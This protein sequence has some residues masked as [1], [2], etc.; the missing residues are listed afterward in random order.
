M[1]RFMLSHSHGP[2]ECGVV[3]AS[4]KAFASPLRGRSVRASCDFG[5][6]HIW[7]E[8]EASSEADALA[9]LPRYVA[10]RTDVVRISELR[11]P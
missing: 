9:Q 8:T 7:W 10:E 5:T 1:S 11:T 3:F 4:F 2:H 6:H